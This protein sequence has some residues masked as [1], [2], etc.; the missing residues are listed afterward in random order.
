MWLYKF[1]NK[2]SRTHVPTFWTFLRTNHDSI[3]MWLENTAE[4]LHLRI[5][6]ALRVI[7]W[8]TSACILFLFVYAMIGPQGEYYMKECEKRL[9][10][11][12]ACNKAFFPQLSCERQDKMNFFFKWNHYTEM[13]LFTKP[14]QEEFGERPLTGKSLESYVSA[15]SDYEKCKSYVTD[16]RVYPMSLAEPFR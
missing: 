14:E 9:E 13:Y 8:I 6:F 4:P 1:I 11:Y 12:N 10:C 2:E 5:H 16:F 3:K 15:V 7:R